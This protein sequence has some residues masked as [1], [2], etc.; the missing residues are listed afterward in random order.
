MG[1]KAHTGSGLYKMEMLPV[2]PIKAIQRW[3][4]RVGLGLLS[5]VFKTQDLSSQHFCYP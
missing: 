1:Q 4:V 3:A 5:S 2:S